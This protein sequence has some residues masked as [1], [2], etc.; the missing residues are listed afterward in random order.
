M[1]KESLDK[2]RHMRNKIHLNTDEAVI[3]HDYNSLN[4]DTYHLSRNYISK[5]LKKYYNEELLNYVIIY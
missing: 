2:L 4:F 5:L 1:D 3:K